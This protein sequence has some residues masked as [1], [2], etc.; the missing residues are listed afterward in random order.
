MVNQPKIIPEKVH[1]SLVYHPLPTVLS[2]LFC[3]RVSW[4]ITLTSRTNV[5]P[6]FD[7]APLSSLSLLWRLMIHKKL[8]LL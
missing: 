1:H 5:Q 2:F 6:R 4:S 3:I 7:H 8:F